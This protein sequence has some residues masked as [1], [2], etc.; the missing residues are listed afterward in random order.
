MAGALGALAE[1][2]VANQSAVASAGAVSVL[3]GLLG[4]RSDAAANN[5]GNAL[6]AIGLDNTESQREIS[7]LLVGLLTTAKRESTQERAAAALWRLVRENPS[8]QMSI[9]QAGGAQPLVRLL[10][11]GTLG[12]RSFALWSLSL[13]INETNQGV[14]VESG[15]IEPLVNMLMSDEK[16]VTEQA[17]GAINKLA[18]IETVE[19]IAKAGAISPLIN[20]LDSVD[21]DGPSV[22]HAA[23]A[24]AAVA[25]AAPQRVSIDHAGGITPLVALLVDPLA[26][27]STK[28]YAAAA[29]ALLSNEDEDVA[30]ALAEEAAEEERRRVAELDQ[31]WELAQAAELA[32]QGAPAP[33]PAAASAEAAAEHIS[34]DQ[35]SVTP[36]HHQS[37]NPPAVPTPEKT[38]K[39]R[40]GPAEVN[41]AD[42][43]TKTIDR[44]PRKR[45]IW[46]EG[47]IPPLVALLALHGDAQEE[48]AAA[49][50]ALAEDARIREAITQAGGIGPL[51][52][53]LGGNNP[54]ARDNAEGALVRM[55]TEMANRVLI[56]EQLVAML[57]NPDI[58]ARE[59]AA[60][61]ISNLAHESTANCSSIVD[62]GGF[63]LF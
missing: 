14:V 63:H 39:K 61:A 19:R 10:R 18:T 60:A 6:S 16:R 5:A 21:S 9:A 20:L 4:S 33:A 35:S 53:L 24:L 7:K 57:H 11:E 29:L 48:A 36:R 38:R 31:Q 32:A 52:A 30:K 8:D 47:A 2:H 27:A 51:V 17:A 56:I 1:G 15:A 62:A 22:Q 28:R 42:N 40:L 23:G 37:V 34:S 26:V 49:L 41:Q 54:Q 59:Q 58:A 50:K 45:A 13:C 12:G 46:N 25:L 43:K 3:V 55:S 44:S